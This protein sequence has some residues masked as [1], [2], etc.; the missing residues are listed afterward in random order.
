MWL[1]AIGVIIVFGLLALFWLG[2][3]TVGEKGVDKV[4]G[5]LDSRNYKKDMI[6][7]ILGIIVLSLLLSGNVYTAPVGD[8][9][10]GETSI[11]YKVGNTIDDINPLNYFKKRK[12]CQAQADRADTVAIG[13][14]WYKDC[15]SRG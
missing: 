9:I 3:F 8:A 15:M 7:K 13:K 11:W 6:K 1:Q 10:I 5:A 14:R 12:K 4:K 2:V